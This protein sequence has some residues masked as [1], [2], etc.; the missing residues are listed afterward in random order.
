MTA[1]VPEVVV[2]AGSVALPGDTFHNLADALAIVPSTQG[3]PL[4]ALQ[5]PLRTGCS[6][7]H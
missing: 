4:S 6:G 1:A 2:V 7:R 3:D 5:P